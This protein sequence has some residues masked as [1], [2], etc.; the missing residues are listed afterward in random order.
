M[1]RTFIRRAEDG[2]RV[3]R[4]HHLRS[5]EVLQRAAALAP[6]LDGSAQNRL[7]RRR[8][9][10]H[11]YLRTNGVDLGSYPRTARRDVNGPGGLVN[12]THAALFETECLHCV[13]DVSGPP[14]APRIA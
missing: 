4:R 3:I 11:D 10:A 14:I 9:E 2:R 6:D 12:A 13:G 8:T 5:G 1:F 7:R